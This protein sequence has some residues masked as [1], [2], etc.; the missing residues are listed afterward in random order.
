MLP[1][2]KINIKNKIVIIRDM[3]NTKILEPV[4]TPVA[5]L[6]LWATYAS[7]RILPNLLKYSGRSSRGKY[8]PEKKIITVIR[9]E[10]ISEATVGS[11]KIS[12]KSMPKAIIPRVLALAEIKYRTQFILKLILNINWESN[13]TTVAEINVTKNLPRIIPTLN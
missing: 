9:T 6:M 11:V 10:P 3:L 8:I 12:L 5:I 4:S 13:N 2:I 7:G 1:L